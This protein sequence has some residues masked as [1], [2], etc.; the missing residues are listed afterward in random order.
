M[1][2][3]VRSPRTAGRDTELTELR[4]L[5]DEAASG[6]SRVVLV[7][8]DAGV[9]KS[10]L[11]AD[12]VDL[13]GDDD[14]WALVGQCIDLGEGG[15][16]FAPFLQIFGTVAQA[17]D[18]QR[19]PEL[20]GAARWEL[21]RL[22]P[23]LAEGHRD[24][25]HEGSGEQRGR[26]FSAAVSALRNLAEDRGPLLVG[27]EDVHWAR[28]S[29]L[30]LVGFLARNLTTEPVLVVITY[31]TDELQRRHPLRPVIGEL[32]RLPNVHRLE[33]EPLDEQAVE[34]QVREILGR[35]PE[36]GVVSQIAERSGGNPFYVE[37][38]VAASREGRP[39]QLRP[40]LRDV[41]AS[42]LDA[43]PDPVRELLDVVAVAGPSVDHRLLGA[44]TD[45][46][47]ADLAR[48]LRP[49]VDQHVLV[50]AGDTYGFRHELV[51]EVVADELL[52]GHRTE[53]HRS[54]ASTL[55][56]HPE[57]A[58]GGREHAD[59]ELAHHWHAAHEMQE[60]FRASIRAARRARE[61]AA[62]AEALEHHE[63][64]LAL[65]DRVEHGGLRR[66]EVLQRAAEAAGAAGHYTRAIAHLRAALD[67]TGDD[68][69]QEADLR[70]RLAAALWS[71]IDGPD[72]AL[73]E[74]ERAHELVAGREPSRTGAAV[75]G[76]HARLLLLDRQQ[77]A[78]D[79]AREAVDLARA[80]GDRSAESHALNTLG[81]SIAFAGDV[82]AGIQHLYEALQI[83]RDAG[84]ELVLE[85]AYNNL[86]LM[87]RDARRARSEIDGVAEEAL[88]WLLEDGPGVAGKGVLSAALAYDATLHGDWERAEDIL[89]WAA[90]H[91]LEGQDEALFHDGRGRL[92]WMQG[93]TDEAARHAQRLR[94]RGRRRSAR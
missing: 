24:V 78:I 19:L 42:R 43:L 7:G 50:V 80:V 32:S 84:G 31:R 74:A 87:L 88:G 57:L 91:H 89:D 21:A 23:G 17:V 14:T 6:R 53:L 61:T 62:F 1:G 11:L 83:A 92:R 22:V 90:R 3:R 51:R 72:A 81:T 34:Q 93:A 66:A 25:D 54:V 13:A 56:E 69:E 60:A 45:H 94:A 59:A 67:D 65:W 64:A 41:V 48:L 5:L 30:D 40:A 35:D 38:L 63:R 15:V 9:G 46:R 12:L 73:R 55:Q 49:A 47:P 75:V 68:P 82:D 79:V 85:R 86:I 37:E 16:P 70:R 18:R 77:E 76:A 36:P 33:L 10:R 27:I 52:P 2:A 58:T 4:S 44:V 39:Y 20:L 26:L 28:S 71:S 8:G 29:T